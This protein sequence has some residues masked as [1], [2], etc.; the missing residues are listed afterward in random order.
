MCANGFFCALMHF[1][2]LN[3][4]AVALEIFMHYQP[5]D[6]AIR[7]KSE[8]KTTNSG[9]IFAK[10]GKIGKDEIFNHKIL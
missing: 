8:G 4:I 5:H 3:Y 9:R 6:R 2:L 7:L 10:S 1:Y